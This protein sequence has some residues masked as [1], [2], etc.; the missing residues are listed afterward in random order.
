MPRSAEQSENKHSDIRQSFAASAL[1]HS[2]VQND[3][4]TKSETPQ[5]ILRSTEYVP[6]PTKICQAVYYRERVS[7]KPS[8]EQSEIS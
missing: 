6:H 3:Q 4:K 5:E 8:A 1:A 7:P 2:P